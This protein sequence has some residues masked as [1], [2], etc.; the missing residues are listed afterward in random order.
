[1]HT[2]GTPRAPSPRAARVEVPRKRV[3]GET[4]ID[5][6]DELRTQPGVG[7]RGE[8]LDAMVEVALHQVGRAHQADDLLT[9]LEDVD[10]RVL[11]EAAH[12]RH[13]ADV[14]ADAGDTRADRA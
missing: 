11:E 13:H 4:A 6:I 9:A 10:A 3:I 5:D 14:L 7:H 12:D 8:H 1:M 2:S